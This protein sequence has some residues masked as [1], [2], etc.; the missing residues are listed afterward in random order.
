MPSSE[1]DSAGDAERCEAREQGGRERGDD[2]EGQRLPVER[3]DR[4]GEHAEPACDEAGEHGVD[5]RQ[6][7]RRQSR[8]RRRDLVLRC[9][10]GR[11]AETAPAVERCEHDR[12]CDHDPRHQQAVEPDVRR[13]RAHLVVLR[14]HRRL[15]LRGVAERHEHRCLQREQDAERGGELRER[16]RGL[17]R[18]EGEQL[19]QPRRRATMMANVL[20]AQPV[21]AASGSRISRRRT[22][23]SAASS[24]CSRRTSR[25]RRWRG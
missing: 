11:E 9:R 23:P 21:R 7:V 3:R 1:P 12:G 25:C 18:P 24:T 16:R 8:E 6:A 5:H 19:H 17:E 10:P 15:R 22:S 13:R 14:Q 20:R 2:V 4:G